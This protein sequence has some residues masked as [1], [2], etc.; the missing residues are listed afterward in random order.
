MGWVEFEI[1]NVPPLR[2][3]GLIVCTRNAA[4]LEEAARLLATG[5]RRVP[6]LF[7]VDGGGCDPRWTWHVDPDTPYWSD[8]GI[9]EDDG[10]PSGIEASK[11]HWAGT[12]KVFAPWTARVVA[13]HR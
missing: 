6:V 5:E 8:G 9:P 12:V 2:A 4:F 13:V 10:C 1:C 3:E 11:Q 7:L